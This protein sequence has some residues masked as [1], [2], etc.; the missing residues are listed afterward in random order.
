M[1]YRNLVPKR[2][3][4]RILARRTRAACICISETWLDVSVTDNEISI[5]KYCI[6]RKDRN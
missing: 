3:E 2:D 5:D 4:L 6:Q 1:N